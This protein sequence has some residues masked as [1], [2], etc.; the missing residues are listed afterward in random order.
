MKAGK[1]IKAAVAG[2]CAVAVAG[3]GISVWAYQSKSSND[4][5]TV[6]KETTVESGNLTVGVTESGSCGMSG[7]RFWCLPPSSPHRKNGA[8]GCLRLR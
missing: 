8:G 6:Y 5:E 3:T 2:I 7:R 4:T 1:K